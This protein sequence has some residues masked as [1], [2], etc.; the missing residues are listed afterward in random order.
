MQER[1]PT[2]DERKSPIGE[3]NDQLTRGQTEEAKPVTA[4]P[5]FFIIAGAVAV[6][7]M[8]VFFVTNH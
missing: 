8:M 7:L 5:W 2:A 1:R 4:I 6:V 3:A